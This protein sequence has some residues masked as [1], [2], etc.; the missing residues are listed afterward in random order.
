[1]VMT[2]SVPI[3]NEEDVENKALPPNQ[4]RTE[5]DWRRQRRAIIARRR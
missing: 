5:E 4:M 1:M 2:A 3:P